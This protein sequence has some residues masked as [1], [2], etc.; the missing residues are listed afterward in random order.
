MKIFRRAM[1]SSASIL[2]AL[3][4]S[5]CGLVSQKDDDD[6]TAKEITEAEISDTTAPDTEPPAPPHRFKDGKT[7]V[8]IDPG[9]GFRDVGCDTALL[10]G[11]ESEVTL[12]VALR[13]KAELENRGAVV[14]LLHDGESFPKE[15]E[16]MAAADRLGIEYKPDSII[17]NDIFSA[18]E[19]AIYASTIG[20]EMAIDLY[21]SLH[22]NSIEGHPEV[23]RYEIDYYEGNP[24]AAF[25][26]DFCATLAAKL[27]TEKK[28]VVFCD[29]YENA[30]IVTKPMTHPSVLIEMGYATNERDSADLNDPA[31]RDAFVKRICDSLDS[32]LEKVH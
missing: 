14:I 5:A 4:L 17:E 16:I 13:L 2:L 21:I 8:C 30:F 15:S 29:D 12:D 19:R 20:E 9:H 31:W 6:T 27:E 1:I 28:A 32:A 7:V 26:A 25:L 24:E 11:T 22:V 18:Y 3:S 23:G 10:N